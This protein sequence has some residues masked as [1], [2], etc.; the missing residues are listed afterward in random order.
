MKERKLESEGNEYNLNF[1]FCKNFYCMKGG[2]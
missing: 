2:E 1:D